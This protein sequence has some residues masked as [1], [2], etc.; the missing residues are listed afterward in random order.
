MTRVHSDAVRRLR[1]ADTYENRIRWKY[2]DEALDGL[3]VRARRLA[4]ATG[5]LTSEVRNLIRESG[6]S[7]LLVRKNRFEIL[8]LPPHRLRRPRLKRKPTKPLSLLV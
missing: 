3:L 7:A 2:H 6:H 8:D 4:A 1:E 5:K